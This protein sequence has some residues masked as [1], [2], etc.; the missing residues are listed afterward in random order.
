MYQEGTEKLKK[1]IDKLYLKVC[2]IEHIAPLM[3]SIWTALLAMYSLILEDS[4]D[5]SLDLLCVEGISN[6]VKLC[7]MLNLDLQKE[8]LLKGFCKMTNLFQGKEIKDKHILCIKSILSL[9]NIDGKFLKG[10]WHNVLELISKI[11]YYH[12]VICVSKSELE[13]FFNE[14]RLKKRTSVNV[15]REILVEKINMERIA[16]EISQD[17]Y[18]IIYNKTVL[19]DQQSIVDFVK[20]LCE[21]SREELAVKENARIFSLQKLVEV[22]EFNMNR[23]RIVWANIW[24]IISEHLTEV[25][26]N[27]SPVVAE[28]AVDS[29]RQLAKKF[30]QKDEISVY[31][32]QKDFLKPFENILVNNINM[33]RTKEYVITCI[34]NLVLAEAPSIKSGWRIIFN[35]FQLAAEDSQKD[36]IRKTFDTI[37]RILDNHFSQVKDNFPELAHCLKKF[38]SSYPEEVVNIFFQTYYKIDERDETVVFALLTSLATI[39]SDQR[40]NVRRIASDK[41]FGIIS[42]VLKNLVKTKRIAG[43]LNKSED[44]DLTIMKGVIKPVIDD[45]IANKYDSTL[46]LVLMNMVDLLETNEG[47]KK[48]INEFLSDLAGIS[49]DQNEA[50]AI[51]GIKTLKYII[52]KNKIFTTHQFDFWEGICSTVSDIFNKTKQTGLLELDINNFNSAEYQQ[53]YQD[54]VFNNIVYCIVQ[55]NMIELCDYIITSHIQSLKLEECLMMLDCLRDS[56]TLAYKFN[57]EFNLRK[58]ISFHFMSDLSQIAALFKQQQDGIALYFKI[59][60][61]LNQKDDENTKAICRKKMLIIS[62]SIL[63]DFIERMDFQIE[64]SNPNGQYL[65]LENERLLKNMVPALVEN[66][67]PSMLNID[68]GGEKDYLNDF[69]QIFLQLIPCGVLEVRLMVKKALARI[70]E[71]ITS[72]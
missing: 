68:F 59:L 48:M 38:A 35:I 55:H 63:K 20:S 67:I 45:L 36:I 56:F 7:G 19:L 49:A 41:L 44:W 5:S 12:M 40:E 18:E 10:C 8:A 3:D 54:I 66:I 34:T 32:F 1:G 21:I 57:I 52:S 4:D 37:C 30:L 29:L 42:N 53:K 33:Y 26:S 43:D 13:V 46:E 47:F 17:D 61:L 65:V 50:I 28:K 69:A 27:P 15:D 11:D 25:G 51:A 64:E 2:E 31:Q 60:N 71:K 16:K 24:T 23:V 14:I 39:V 6:C 9:A 70:L 62:H 22:A 72:I 58:L